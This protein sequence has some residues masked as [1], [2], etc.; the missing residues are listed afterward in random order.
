[1]RC[2]TVLLHRNRCDTMCALQ[3]RGAT[4]AHQP[5]ELWILVRVQ[6]PLPIPAIAGLL[7]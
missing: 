7:L 2:K 6:A 1:M 5:L 3:G 4:A